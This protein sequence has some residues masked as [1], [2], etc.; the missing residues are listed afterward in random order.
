[1]DSRFVPVLSNPG[2]TVDERRVVVFSIAICMYFTN[3][4]KV[5]IPQLLLTLALG[6][7]A[8][9]GTLTASLIQQQL[10]NVNLTTQGAVDWAVWGIGSST[11]LARNNGRIGGNSISSLTD[12]SAGSPLRGLGQFGNYGE[13]TFNWSN[14]TPTLNGTGVATGIQ[15]NNATGKI[16]EG[17][18][19]TVNASTTLQRMILYFDTHLGISTL[20][21][22]LSDSSAT[23]FSQTFSAPSGINLAGIFTVDFAANSANQT[24]NISVLLTTASDPNANVAIQGVAVSNVVPEPGAFALTG[25]GAALLALA[26]ARRR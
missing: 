13:S 7:S 24:L 12:I 11:S 17:F 20:T 15:H 2:A 18:S 5:S 3:T 6:Q 21:A 22:S 26:A 16:N 9:A 4:L 25:L 19:Y 1:M 14:G 23:A 10:N 8:Q